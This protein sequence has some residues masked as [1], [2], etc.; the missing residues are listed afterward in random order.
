[1]RVEWAAMRHPLRV[2]ATLSLLAFAS[3]VLAVLFGRRPGAS[4]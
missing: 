3:A 4:S 1:V 2:A